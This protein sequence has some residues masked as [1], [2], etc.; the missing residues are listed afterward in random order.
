MNELKRFGRSRTT[1]CPHVL[2]HQKVRVR[3]NGKVMNAVAASNS[4]ASNYAL[5]VML[6]GRKELCIWD[7]LKGWVVKN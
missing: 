4:V 2:N 3:K 1:S 6:N 5:D 7:S